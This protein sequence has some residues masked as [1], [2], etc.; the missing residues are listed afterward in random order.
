MHSCHL[1]GCA[2]YCGGDIDDCDVGDIC[3]QGCGCEEDDFDD[4]GPVEC[5]CGRVACSEACEQCGAPLCPMCFETGVGFCEKHPD[6]S[7]RP[8][9]GTHYAEGK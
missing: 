1:C 2:C 6:D 5:R 8:P 9:E 4:A 7:Y 3:R